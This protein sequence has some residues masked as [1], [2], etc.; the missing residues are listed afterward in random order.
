MK[1]KIAVILL[2]LAALLFCLFGCGQDASPVKSRTVKQ[3]GKKVT[4]LSYTPSDLDFRGSHTPLILFLSD[5]VF[6]K[7][8]ALQAIIANGLKALADRESCTVIFLSPADGKAWSSADYTRLQTVAGSTK[9]SWFPGDASGDGFSGGL[10]LSS[11]FRIYVFAEGSAADFVK[12]TLD[13]P[14]ADFLITEYGMNCGGFAAGYVYASDGFTESSVTAGWASVKGR[15]RMFT[16]KDTSL[17]CICLDYADLGITVVKSFYTAASGRVIEYYA[18]TPAS[19]AS[20]AVTPLVVLFHGRGMHPDAYAYQSAWP[21]AAAAHG[22]RIISVAGPYDKKFST[23]IDDGITADTHELITAY[24]QSNP[25]DPS[26]VYATGFSMGA[27]R[28]LDLGAKYPGTF[29]AIAPCDPVRG[30]ITFTAPL[31]VFLFG[32]AID[33]YGIFPTENDWCGPLVKSMAEANGITVAFDASAGNLWGIRFV[34]ET[35][36]TDADTGLVIHLRSLG[37]SDSTPRII[38]AEAE[39]MGHTV[40]PA[41]AEIIWSFFESVR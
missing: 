11:H 3:H 12:K 30:G 37:N 6:T 24:V 35:D 22:F 27:F 36:V 25:V 8:S 15:T 2:A 39:N 17:A 4:V 38:L 7:E 18:Y 41:M 16:D 29:A 9:D 31:P 34:N 19:V 14:G 40:L 20:D 33:N 32:G 1:M 5:A 10:F 13:V 28:V 23:E 26:R 21:A